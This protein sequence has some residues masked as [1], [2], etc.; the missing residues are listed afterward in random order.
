[1]ICEC[2]QWTVQSIEYV[3]LVK[4][5]PAR[6]HCEEDG[7]TK[8]LKYICFPIMFALQNDW[9]TISLMTW[10][11]W[12]PNCPNW[13]QDPVCQVSWHV[14]A[15]IAFPWHL[16]YRPPYRYVWKT[17]SLRE[18]KPF[19]PI[20]AIFSSPSLAVSVSFWSPHLLFAQFLGWWKHSQWF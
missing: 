4:S 19:S 7:G 11:K 3:I 13:S 14:N 8:W 17:T 10:R 15:K 5:C 12:L 6:P 1:M 20:W 18:S 9:H 16:S 2:L